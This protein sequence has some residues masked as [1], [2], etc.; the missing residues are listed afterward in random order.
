MRQIKPSNEVLYNIKSIKS[1]FNIFNNAVKITPKRKSDD[2]TEKKQ[3]LLKNTNSNKETAVDSTNSK[4][5]GVKQ[6]PKT[7]A[8]NSKQKRI[9]IRCQDLIVESKK[10][11]DSDN[12][13]E[14]ALLIKKKQFPTH[15]KVRIFEC[16]NIN[17]DNNK[18]EDKDKNKDREKEIINNSKLKKSQSMN[19]VILGTQKDEN[20][21]FKTIKKKLFC[22]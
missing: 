1:C 17:L 11:E 16:N 6:F 12:H 10:S 7:S 19:K 8:E 15:K 3:L 21:F 4:K 9:Y 13:L 22:C 18:D 20:K 2:I 5:N 14:L